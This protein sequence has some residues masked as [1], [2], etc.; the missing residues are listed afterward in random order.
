MAGLAVKGLTKAFGRQKVIEGLSFEASE[1]EFCVLLGPSGCGKST[2]LRL[3]AGLERPDAGEIHIGDTL[4][5]ELDPSE[6]DVAMVFQ[7]YALYPHMDVYENMAFPL[8][9]KKLPKDEIEKKVGDAARLLGME[10][11]LRRKPRELSGGQRQR[12]AM[13]RAIVRSPK[14]FLF[15]EPLSNLDARLRTA[16][17]VELASLHKKLGITTVYVTHDQVE[18]MTLADRI[19]LIEDGRL[20][21]RGT[22]RELYG[23]PANIFAA[24]FM[25]SP[26]INLIAGRLTREGDRVHFTSDVLS[27][28]VPDG[29]ELEGYIGKDITLGVRHEAL[30]P[31]PGPLKGVVEL[32][33]HIGSETVVFFRAGG[34]SKLA[35]RAAASFEC[36]AGEEIALEID[37]RSLHFF[38]E[39]ERIGI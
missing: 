9:V 19:I 4:V 8:K 35:A 20:R 6:R 32:V 31:G 5:N 17:R 25:G 10:G 26:R 15:D 2:V 33:E 34:Y 23:S 27:I 37:A 12:A 30:A 7:S 16:M 13:G 29:A 3:I 36:R 18:A 22:P 1:G 38:Y 14:L 21:Q 24:T 28:E 39:G 11:L